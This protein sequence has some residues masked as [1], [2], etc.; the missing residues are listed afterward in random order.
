MPGLSVNASG[1]TGGECSV[2]NGVT[3]MS[4]T[5]P[6]GADDVNSKGEIAIDVSPKATTHMIWAYVKLNIYIIFSVAKYLH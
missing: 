2:V 3:T 6:A 1:V 4:F 5:R